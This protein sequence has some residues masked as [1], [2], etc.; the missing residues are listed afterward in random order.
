M[1]V[2]LNGKIEENKIKHQKKSFF[3]SFYTFSIFNL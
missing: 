2:S 1:F 3:N